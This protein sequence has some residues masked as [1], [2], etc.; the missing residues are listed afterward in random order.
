MRELKE[1]EKHIPK[2]YNGLRFTAD[3]NDCAMPIAMDSHSGC[4]F[5]CLYCFS[6]NLM[7]NPD[8]YSAKA[9]HLRN[10]GVTQTE[11]DIRELYKFLRRELTGNV[12]EAMYPLLDKGQPVQLGALGE[13]FDRME[14]KTGWALKALE[15][16]KRFDQ[17]VR[18]STK[19]GDVILRDE[20]LEAFNKASDN[21]WVNFSIIHPEDDLIKKIDLGAPDASTRF[22]AMKALSDMG[23]KTGLRFRPIIPQLAYKK[24]K[25]GRPC[26]QVMIDKAVEAG[27]T[28]LS[29]EIV[30]LDQ[31]ATEGQRRQYRQMSKAIGKQDFPEWWKQ[32]SVAGQSCL[33][34]NRL[35]KWGLLSNIRD[36]AKEQGLVVGISTPHF[37]EYGETVCCCGIPEDDPVFGGF[38]DRNTTKLV[39]EGRR[40]YE[41][42]GEH[43]RF[44]YT[45]WAPEWA[46]HIRK[47]DMCAL[48]S[49]EGHHRF[50]DCTWYDDQRNKWNN[51]R[52]FRSPYYYYEGILHP[53]DVDDQGDVVYE[54][55]HWAGE[56]FKDV[57]KLEKYKKLD[58][59]P[60]ILKNVG[61]VFT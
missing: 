60:D 51:P 56:V 1:S 26:W 8:R 10:L 49:A 42:S 37:K 7:R 15:A 53:V 47:A 35:L 33:R 54:Y 17:P 11:W 43:L 31:G 58:H 9:E 30:F 45:D 32:H 13:P 61:S 44:S 6:N 24:Y 57:E 27:A 55:R 23:V 36:Y 29:Y 3:A 18:I 4:S 38:T 5:N 12:P 14:E 50:Q 16:F 59:C 28:G 39:I 25:D 40:A 21:T 46:K 2:T 34:A 52:H 48:G 22:E 41:E 19:G 20:Y